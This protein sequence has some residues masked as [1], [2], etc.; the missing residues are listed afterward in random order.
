MLRLRYHTRPC[1]FLAAQRCV[2]VRRGVCLVSWFL[3]CRGDKAFCSLECRHHQILMDDRAACF[4]LAG[5]RFSMVPFL[6]PAQDRLSQP[7]HRMAQAPGGGVPCWRPQQGEGSA[8]N[9]RTLG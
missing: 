4:K 2:P 1:L 5:K 8:S 7:Q 6:G 9:V 3:E